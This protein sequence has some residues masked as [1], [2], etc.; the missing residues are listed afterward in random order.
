M[1]L[2]RRVSSLLFTLTLVVLCRAA[3]ALSLPDQLALAEKDEDT[4]AQIELIRRI[5][6][7]KPDDD[8]LREQLAD[9]WLSVED[10]DMAES[11]VREWTNAPESVRVSVLAAVLFV[12]DQ[13]KDEAVA[14]AGRLSGQT[15]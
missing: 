5:L 14:S 15:S 3:V 10:Y 2:P 4:H 11:T 1:K 6:D 9:L 8:E 7:E 12:R 13:K